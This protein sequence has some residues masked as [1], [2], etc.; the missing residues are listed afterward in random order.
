VAVF[1]FVFV[2]VFVFVSVCFFTITILPFYSFGTS[3]GQFIQHP[4]F[5]NPFVKNHAENKKI[6]MKTDGT[7][8]IDP[9]IEGPI[10]LQR[11]QRKPVKTTP[12]TL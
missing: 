12:T 11:N 8:N 2:F 10:M 7:S 4:F 6:I 5:A 3:P 9:V 1:I